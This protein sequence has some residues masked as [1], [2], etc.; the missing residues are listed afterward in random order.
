MGSVDGREVAVYMGHLV[1]MLR[2]EP[3][4]T[5]FTTDGKAYEARVVTLTKHLMLVEFAVEGSARSFSAV[6]LQHSAGVT[7]RIFTA[8]TTRGGSFHIQVTL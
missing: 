6:L 8:V 4:A 2:E 3:R 1:N 7:Y 5:L